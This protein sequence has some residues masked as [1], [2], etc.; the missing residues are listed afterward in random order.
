[1]IYT[2]ATALLIT[3]AIMLA[4][5]APSTTASEHRHL[6]SIADIRNGWSSFTDSL[7]CGG[8][9][10]SSLLSNWDGE[11][12]RDCWKCMNHPTV[13]QLP[14]SATSDLLQFKL[15]IGYTEGWCGRS[16]TFCEGTACAS[17][18]VDITRFPTGWKP[19][20]NGGYTGCEIKTNFPG[21][22]A[23]SH[24]SHAYVKSE[25]ATLPRLQYEGKV[26]RGNE[27]GFIIS[28]ELFW[29]NVSPRTVGLGATVAQHMVMRPILDRT[30]GSCDA[31]CTA[32]LQQSVRT[33]Q[34]ARTSVSVQ[35]DVVAWVHEEL[36]KRVFPGVATLP[37]HATEFVSLQS[38][39]TSLST[40]TQLL[41]DD[42][43]SLIAGSTLTK[44]QAAYDAYYPLVQETYGAE[45]AGADCSPMTDCV[46]LA[47]SNILDALFFAG[48]LSVPSGISTGLWVLHADT[49]SYGETFPQDP[50]VA[51]PAAFFY[52]SIRFFPP[53]VGFPWWTTPPERASDDTKSQA[54]GG[55]RK[56]LNLALANKDPNAWGAD[57]HQFRVRRHADYANNFVGFADHA[58]DY[59]VAEGKMN[60]NCPAKQ[61]ALQ[62][63]KAF[64]TEWEQEGWCTRDSTGYQEATPFVDAFTLFRGRRTGHSCSPNPNPWGTS[65]CCVGHCGWEWSG[66]FSGSFK[67]KA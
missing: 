12:S 56:V 34:A 16:R 67:C 49:S 10:V 43:S 57:A 30:L 2:A 22:N 13:G 42:L 59:S 58:Y 37:V 38:S 45:L 21:I 61:L 18:G 20:G 17:E 48:G 50:I 55:V 41:S 19:D 6:L 31:S 24:M 52:E 25:M 35:P 11:V 63:G 54:A 32:A 26:W 65:E 47:T 40:I 36:F 5:A 46:A 28:N 62:M 39:L 29:P 53:V 7:Q 23:T 60:R 8:E 66:W 44:L 15:G 33:W 3:D 1:M 14:F 51:D 64:F 9:C 27:L 4:S